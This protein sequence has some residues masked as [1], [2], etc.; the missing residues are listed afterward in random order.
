VVAPNFVGVTKATKFIDADGDEYTVKIKGPG[1]LQVAL[2]D[3]DGDGNGSIDQMSITGSAAKT[4]VS[5]AVKKKGGD[6]LIEIGDVNIHGDLGSF[7]ASKADLILGLIATGTIG[8]IKVHDVV[9]SDPILAE[10]GFV[11]GGGAGGSTSISANALGDG[12]RIE[13]AGA[14]KSLKAREIG[15]GALQAAALGAVKVSGDM[16]AA[17][18][19]TGNIAKIT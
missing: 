2:L 5:I 3:P 1:T 16:A 11:I 4:K 12:F 15:A 9:V 7:S 10:I 8:Q 18:Q 14:I 17:L 19:I 13:A 6:G